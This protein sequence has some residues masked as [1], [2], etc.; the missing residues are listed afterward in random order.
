MDQEEI[1]LINSD[2]EKKQKQKEL[3]FMR[4]NAQTKPRN[5]SRQEQKIVGQAMFLFPFL[6]VVLAIFIYTKIKERKQ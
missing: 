2:K 3:E 6:I 4:Q 5:L 1:L